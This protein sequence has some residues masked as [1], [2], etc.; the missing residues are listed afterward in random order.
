MTFMNWIRRKAGNHP[1]LT[2]TGATVPVGLAGM[3]SAKPA[4]AE[5]RIL[6]GKSMNLADRLAYVDP[7]CAV[8]PVKVNEVIVTSYKAHRAYVEVG[9][10]INPETPEQGFR[11]LLAASGISYE[12]LTKGNKPLVLGEGQYLPDAV[13]EYLI[14]KYLNDCNCNKTVNVPTVQVE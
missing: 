11:G 10:Q 9:K 3:L 14:N 2:L 8:K 6:D 7:Q 12:Q 13:R 4:Q 5:V 1:V